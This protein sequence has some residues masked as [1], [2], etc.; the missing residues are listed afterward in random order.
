MSGDLRRVSGAEEKARLAAELLGGVPADPRL[1]TIE[2]AGSAVPLSPAAV[3]L[4]AALRSGV[5][6]TF[7]EL[8]D[9]HRDL[10]ARGI[11]AARWR[12]ARP[13]EVL[14]GGVVV[15]ANDTVRS[16][17][18][19]GIQRVVRQ[20]LREWRDTRETQLVAWSPD[21]RRLHR[22]EPGAFEIDV[23]AAAGR[24]VPLIPWGGRFIVPEL[25]AEA[26][27]LDRI[28]AMAESTG[29]GC[30][31]IGYD[32]VPVTSAETTGGGMPGAFA[33]NLATLSRFAVIAPIS[34]AAAGEYRGWARMLPSAGL[35]APDI[36][37]VPLP[38]TGLPVPPVPAESP[39]SR[40]L[41]LCVGS[42]EPRK[43]H[44]AVVHAA[45]ILWREG[46]DFELVFVG[47]NAWAAE[48]VRERIDR[49]AAEGRPISARSAVSDDDLARLYGRARFSVFPSL[50]EGFG[51]PVAESIAVGVPVVT[52]D[53]GSMR[54]IA[55]PGGAVLV[56]PRDDHAIAAAMRTLLTD[57]AEHARVAAEA[58]A[59]ELGSWAGYADRLW[60]VLVTP[61]R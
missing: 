61:G 24:R 54:E 23:P 11:A 41:V 29:I 57:D 30:A 22:E 20:T 60:D 26:S 39:A 36:M 32:L 10:E 2:L 48:A 13:V 50:N 7:A 12:G 35:D 58:A 25:A 52:S 43:N 55:E 14:V 31:A 42:H 56:D 37:A 47:G 38:I 27:R 53:F 18:A 19:T 28:R 46:L 6:P 17:L 49:L 5:L 16:R 8:A 4:I 45:E 15:D 34:E 59:R 33:R 51:L 1:P 9:L 40:P 44:G 3:W 21:L